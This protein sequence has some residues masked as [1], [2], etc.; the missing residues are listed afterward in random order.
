MK[1]VDAIDLLRTKHPEA[2]GKWG[3]VVEFCGIDFLAVAL[4]QS[5]GFAVYGYEI[6]IS[7]GDWLRELRQ[8]DKA[9]ESMARCDFWLLAAPPGVLKSTEELP[10]YWGYVELRETPVMVVRPTRL[11]EPY[12]AK[13]SPKHRDFYQRASFAMM[14]R[15]MI[16]ERADRVA[17]QMQLETGD[18]TAALDVAALNTGRW[19][20][21]RRAAQ[22]RRTRRRR[23]PSRTTKGR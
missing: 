14:T 4:W 12:N 22:R 5:L 20:S 17:L 8:P 23:G 2:S 16:Y 3:T 19:T 21:T 9:R 7:R 1:T 13:L 11:R 6:K 10:E 15:R 18:A